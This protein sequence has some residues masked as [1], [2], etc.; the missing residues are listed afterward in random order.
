MKYNAL[1]CFRGNYMIPLCLILWPLSLLLTTAQQQ[2]PAPCLALPHPS[3]FAAL[4]FVSLTWPI[5]SHSWGQLEFYFLRKILTYYYSWL[6]FILTPCLF[7]LQFLGISFMSLTSVCHSH[8]N[9]STMIAGIVC[10][11]YHWI[12]DIQHST[13][14]I[15]IN[16]LNKEAFRLGGT[17][18][19][20]AYESDPKTKPEVP[21]G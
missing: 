6:V 7:L 21:Q 4:C 18:A 8:W 15:V 20:S 19:L 1:P 2:W 17:N 3:A 16:W 12:L 11:G 10:P 9:M 14:D 13:W 5:P